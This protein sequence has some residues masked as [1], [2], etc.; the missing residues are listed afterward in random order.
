MSHLKHIRVIAPFTVFLVILTV[1]ATASTAL[2]QVNEV[3]VSGPSP[4]AT[5]SIAGQSGPGPSSAGLPPGIAI[6]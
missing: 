1:L 6:P 4:Y 2:A 3:T 5:C